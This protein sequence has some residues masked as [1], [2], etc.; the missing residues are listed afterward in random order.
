MKWLLSAIFSAQMVTGCIESSARGHS[1][2]RRKC[3]GPNSSLQLIDQQ[4]I[5]LR[6]SQRLTLDKLRFEIYKLYTI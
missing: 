1:G 4:T 3:P 5:V 2:D 6:L